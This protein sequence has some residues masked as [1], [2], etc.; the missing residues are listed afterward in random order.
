MEMR[1]HVHPKTDPGLFTVSFWPLCSSSLAS[2]GAWATCRGVWGL[3]HRSSRE[4]PVQHYFYQPRTRSYPNAHQEANTNITVGQGK[5]HWKRV[6]AAPSRECQTTRTQR[7]R[8][9]GAECMTDRDTDKKTHSAYKLKKIQERIT[10]ASRRHRGPP[11]LW[12]S[13]FLT[14]AHSL[15]TPHCRFGV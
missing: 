10:M 1:T 8:Q 3:N 14:H 7:Q 2:D 9:E 13:P 12:N 6:G 11:S 5:K 4:L 15:H